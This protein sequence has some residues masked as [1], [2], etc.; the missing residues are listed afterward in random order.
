MEILKGVFASLVAV[1]VCGFCPKPEWVAARC[2]EGAVNRMPEPHRDRMREEWYAELG[3]QPGGFWTLCWALDLLRG[4]G[5]VAEE[6]EEMEAER[7]SSSDTVDNNVE[8]VEEAVEK[9]GKAAMRK[10]LAETMIAE[11][12]MRRVRSE[13]ERMVTKFNEER[14]IQ[15]QELDKFIKRLKTK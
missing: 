12:D 10:T 9:A 13:S 7:T 4:A 11:M 6:L 8:T 1:V 5:S 3:D 15:L 2:I 14:E